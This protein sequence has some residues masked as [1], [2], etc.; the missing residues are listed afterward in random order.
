V[1]KD[2]KQEHEPW[3]YVK[4]EQ[5][6]EHKPREVGE[7]VHE[8][9]DDMKCDLLV[10]GPSVDWATVVVMAAGARVG[11]V[12]PWRTGV[13]QSAVKGIT[14]HIFMSNTK[15]VFVCYYMYR[16]VCPTNS[17]NFGVCFTKGNTRRHS[18]THTYTH[19]YVDFLLCNVLRNATRII[20]IFLLDVSKSVETHI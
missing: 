11:G 9:C 12:G 7:R 15:K 8:P 2:V 16:I 17:L 4:P 20:M 3:E 5:E 13:N 10:V 19:Y 14:T 6:T 18:R 1:P